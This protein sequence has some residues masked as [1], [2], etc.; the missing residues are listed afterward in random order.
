MKDHEPGRSAN[1]ARASS[2][3]L[4]WLYT[5]SRTL[6]HP[7]VSHAAVAALYGIPEIDLQHA[8]LEALRWKGFSTP[9]ADQLQNPAMDWKAP[10]QV[11]MTDSVHPN[12]LAHANYA[13]TIVAYLK[14]QVD[15]APSPE[16]RDPL[17]GDEFA[18]VKLVAPSAARR[19]GA[20]EV[21]PASPNEP[22]LARY[23]DGAI[24]ARR[25]GDSLEFGFEGTA[26]GLYLDVQK[27]GGRYEW[28]IDDGK[29][30]PP[31]PSSSAGL[32]AS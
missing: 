1:P 24:N 16:L 10:S 32:L 30:A 15:A 4:R 2:I 29:G 9:S 25:P 27:D 19:T 14:T 6:D 13:E 3:S 28:T 20:W 26:L 31:A 11:F 22:L 7:R 12:E 23:K 8:L 21:V 17:I 18:R 5:T